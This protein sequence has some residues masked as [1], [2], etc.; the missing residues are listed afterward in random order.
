MN[1]CA[2]GM[3]MY[4]EVHDASAIELQAHEHFDQY[5]AQGEWFSFDSGTARNVGQVIRDMAACYKRVIKKGKEVTRTD[6]SLLR[7]RRTTAEIM[8]EPD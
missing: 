3:A 4:V 8:A 1:C 5:R 6:Y 2:K 7:T